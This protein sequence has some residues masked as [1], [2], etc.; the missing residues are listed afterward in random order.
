M[1]VDEN[2]LYIEKILLEQPEININAVD[3]VF[4]YLLI[5]KDATPLHISCKYGNIK[6][7]S[8]LLQM[9]DIKIDMLMNG[10]TAKDIANEKGYKDIEKSIENYISIQYK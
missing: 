10:K 2:S 4:F 8:L 5:Y 9:K 7:V 3:I 1:S 6:S